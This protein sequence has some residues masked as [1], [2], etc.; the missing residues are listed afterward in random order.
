MK[1]VDILRV[2]FGKSDSTSFKVFADYVSIL[3]R[4]SSSDVLS[5]EF[6]CG[7]RNRL[8]A[9]VVTIIPVIG[10]VSSSCVIW[11]YSHDIEEL[12]TGTIT[13]IML[14]HLGSKLVELFVDR[15]VHREMLKTVDENTQSLQN[16]PELQHIGIATFKRARFFVGFSTIVYIAALISLVLY[17]LV[18][19][20]TTGGYKL[21]ANLELPGTNNKDPLGWLVNYL[22]SIVLVNFACFPILGKTMSL[23]ITFFAIQLFSH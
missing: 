20:L 3:L 18:P 9:L 2:V 15:N 11:K 17:P 23:M 7:L 1:L 13:F 16:D 8:L 19:F 6:N 5:N 4:A 12:I 14:V 21:G 22:F 10:I